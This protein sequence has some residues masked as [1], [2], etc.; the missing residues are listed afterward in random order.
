MNEADARLTL[1]V[2]AWETAPTGSV[3]WSDEDRAWAS[4]GAALAEGEGAPADAFVAAR[5]RLAAARI[6]EREPAARRMLRALR[7][8]PWAVWTLAAISLALG[9]ATDA[10]GASRQVNVLAPPLLA[11]M[12][13]NLAVYAAGAVRGIGGQAAAGPLAR[14]LAPVLARFAGLGAPLRSGPR[15]EAGAQSG[16][17]RRE[18][19]GHAAALARF[20]RDWARSSAVLNASRVARMLHLSAIAFALGALAGMYLRGLAFEYRAGWESTFLDAGQVRAILGIVLGPAAALTGIP[21]PDAASLHAIRLPGPGAEAAPWIHLYA[22]TVALVVVLPRLALAARKL[23]IERGLADRFPLALDEPY[24]ATLARSHRGEAATVV[25]APWN[26]RASPAAE[27]ALRALSARLFGPTA[28]A[29]ILDPV[30]YGDEERAGERVF[31]ALERLRESPDSSQRQGTAAAV[32]ALLPAT[33]TPETET[34][35]VFVDALAAALPA[36]A[37]LLALVDASAFVTRFGDDSL[38]AR[39]LEERRLAWTRMLSTRGRATAFLDLER[40]DPAAA[41][42]ELG[43]ALARAARA[44]TPMPATR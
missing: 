4:R 25:V 15:A 24:F 5:A 30:A 10:L 28:K 29:D 34:H 39:R 21:L 6:A 20:G 31:A 1:L 35:G 16:E 26:H 3:A 13:W 44:A 40:A 11:L 23:A 41:E 42:R 7:W 14:L 2:R 38:A 8:R 32:V 33:A 12:L 19:S 27:R 17:Q 22:V 36:G 18:E 37:P 9:L 43:E